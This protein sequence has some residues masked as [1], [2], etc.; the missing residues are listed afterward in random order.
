MRMVNLAHPRSQTPP[1]RRTEDP[2]QANY[3][4]VRVYE[5]GR[6]AVVEPMAPQP[7]A[8]FAEAMRVERH[9]VQPG[10]LPV[11]N[12]IPTELGS[13]FFMW[14]QDAA[15]GALGRRL[16]LVPTLVLNGPRNARIDTRLLGTTPVVRNADGDYLFPAETA[17]ADCAHVFAVVQATLSRFERARDGVTIPWAWNMNGNTDPITIFPRAGN[18]ANAFYSRTQKAL[19]F[20]AYTPNATADVVFTCRSPELVAHQTAHAILDGLKP[21]WLGLFSPPQ[22]GALSEAFADLAAILLMLSQADLAASLIATTKADLHAKRFLSALAEPP[23]AALARAAGLRNADNDL[24]LSQVSN[25]VHLLSQVFTG[26]VYDILSDIFKFERMRQSRT[27]DAVH[28]LLEV[29]EHI[30][31][32]LL[33]AVSR[34]PQIGA[35]FADVVNQMLKVSREWN[36]PRI[37]RTFIYDRFALRKVVA[38]DGPLA[39]ARGEIEWDNP[40]FSDRMDEAAELAPA[41]ADHPSLL[42][43]QDRSG[44]CGTMQ[45]PEYA[46]EP[47]KLDSEMHRLCQEGQTI[48]ELELVAEEVEALKKAF[49]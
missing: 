22:T 16:T 25:E 42:T 44:C 3:A 34:A 11:P 49:A 40:D 30:A 21:A 38:A 41:Q 35:T 32:L 20:Y 4:S 33:A 23:G 36:T 14:M 6:T 46:R 12:P 18:T 1:V 47:R 10:P 27:K 43:R 17:E 13:R 19:K 15:V 2:P 9:A 37:Y 39:M 29:N 5:A 45:L 26:A 31:K 48:S 8:E 28:L 7:T 24:K